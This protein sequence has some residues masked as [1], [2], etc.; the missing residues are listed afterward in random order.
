MVNFLTIEALAPG[1]QA[2][3]P[4]RND[5]TLSPADFAEVDPIIAT[6]FG[7]ALAALAAD[8]GLLRTVQLK[9]FRSPSSTTDACYQSIV[10]GQFSANNFQVLNPPPA[11]ININSYATLSIAATLGLDASMPLYPISQ[12][13]ATCDLVYTHEEAIF[14]NS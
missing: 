6:A 14:V 1:T 12:Y 8:P 4:V 13:A 3:I 9:E 5:W 2:N 10:E 11:Q 7:P